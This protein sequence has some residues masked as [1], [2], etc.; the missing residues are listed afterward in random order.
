[1]LVLSRR[2][3]E[4]IVVSD[5]VIVRVSRIQGNRVQLAIEA[6]RNISVDREEV[7]RAKRVFAI[8]V[9]SEDCELAAIS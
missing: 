3:G 5:T 7:L 8:P 9:D 2:S 1:M 4:A 6:P